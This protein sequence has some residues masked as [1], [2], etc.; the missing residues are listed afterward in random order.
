MSVP[1]LFSGGLG[2]R[3]SDEGDEYVGPHEVARVLGMSPT[4]VMRWAAHGWL[5]D[6]ITLHGHRGFRREDGEAQAEHTKRQEK[7]GS[8]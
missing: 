1:S 8:D 4:T 2:M 3:S 7:D 6:S 5:S